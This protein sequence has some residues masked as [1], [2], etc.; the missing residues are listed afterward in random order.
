MWHARIAGLNP[1]RK[2]SLLNVVKELKYK[3]SDMNATV[4]LKIVGL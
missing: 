2:E 1:H 4:G 3:C